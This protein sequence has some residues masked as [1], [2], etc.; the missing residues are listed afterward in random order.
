MQSL[1]FNICQIGSDLRKISLC[2]C[3]TVIASPNVT[4]TIAATIAVKALAEAFNTEN[5]RLDEESL[6]EEEGI[7]VRR[8]GELGKLPRCRADVK[9]CKSGCERLL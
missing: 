6:P 4:V 5:D 7:G 1:F 9:D 3:S 2:L 8:C